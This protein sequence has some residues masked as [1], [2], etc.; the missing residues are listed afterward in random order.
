MH[1]VTQTAREVK[2]LKETT[3]HTIFTCLRPQF[4]IRKQHS[5]SSGGSTDENMMMLDD[6]DVNMAIWCIFLHATLRAAEPVRSPTPKLTISPTLYSV[7]K[8]EMEQK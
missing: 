8:W 6:L 4:I 2:E 3:G 7:G 1:P 5:R